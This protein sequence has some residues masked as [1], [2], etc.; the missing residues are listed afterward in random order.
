LRVVA[1]YVDGYGAAESVA[2]AATE[3]VANVND[4]PS[5]DVTLSGNA[6]QYESLTASNALADADGLGNVGYQWQSSID[7][8]TWSAING[9]TGSS[10]VLGESQVGQRVRVIANYIDGHGSAESVTSATTAPVALVNRVMGTAG[11]DVL[12]GTAIADRFEGLEG[13]DTY[14]VD[15]VDDVVIENDNEGMDVVQSAVTYSLSS[16]VEDLYLTGTDAING[17]GNALGNRL[18]GNAAANILSGLDGNDIITDAYG[19]ADTLIGGTGNDNLSGGD[20]ADTYVFARGFGQDVIA[21]YDQGSGGQDIIRFAADILA[22][23]V[24]LSRNAS[25]LFLKVLGTEDGITVTGFYSDP[26]QSIERVEFADSTV[27]NATTLVAATFFGTP[28]VDYIYGTT[29]NDTLLGLAGNDTLIADAGNDTLDGGT[30]NDALD[31]GAGNDAFIFATGYGQDTISDASGT[32]VITLGSGLTNTDVKIWRDASNLYVGITGTS[33]VLTVQG[34]YDLSTNRVESIKFADGTI[35]SST[36]L[37]AAPFYGATGADALYGTSGNDVLAGFAGD[38]SLAGDAGNDTLDG[39]TGNDALDGGAGNDSFIFATGYGQDTISDMSGTDVIT[40]GSGLTTTDVKIWRDTSN[41]YVGITGTSDVLTVQGWYDLTTNRV[42]SIKFADGTIWN[43]TTLA[44]APFFGTA[45]ADSLAGT[46][47]NDMLSGFSGNDALNGDA[48]NDTLDGGTGIDYLDGGAG[49]DTYVFARGYGQDTVTDVSG[50]DVITLG[51]GL[52]TADVKIW[53]DTS[54]LYV[55]IAGTADVLTVQG[56]YDLSTNRVES[57]KFADGTIWSATTLAAAPFFGTSGADSLSGTTGNDMLSGFG[58]NDAVYA[59]AGNDT[60]D[61]GTGNDLLDGGAGNDIYLFG[62]GYG[63]DTISETSGTADVVQM[64]A[65]VTPADIWVSRDASNLYLSIKGTAD[66]LSFQNWYFGSTYQIEQIKFADNTTWTV[67]DLNAKTSSMTEGDDFVWGTTGNDTINGLGGDDQL[68]GSDGNDTLS[69]GAGNDLLNGGT[70]IDSMVGGTGDDVYVVNI[71]GDAV[72]ELANE[73]TDTV[74]SSVTHTLGANVENLTLLDI[75]GAINGTGNTLDNV[76]IG[77]SVVNTLNGGAGA[78]TLIGGLGND[79]Y[80]V[81]NTGDSIV[82][83]AGEGTDTVQASISY[84]L[85]ANVENLTLTGTTALSGTGND[86]N[87]S[88]TGNSGIN[89]LTGGAG[90]DVLNGGAGA[91]TLIGGLGNDTYTVDNAGD[92]VAEN[93][94]EGTDVV[95]STISYTLGADVE[96]LTLTGAAITSGTGNELNNALTGNSAANTLSGGAGNDTLNGGAGADTLN[97]GLGNDSYT[98]DN[99]GDVIVESADEGTDIVNSSVTHSLAAN[100]ENLTLTGAAVINGTGNTFDNVLTGNSAT[101]VLTGG[102]GNDVLN[103]AAGADTLIGGAGNDTYTA[104]NIGDVTVENAGEGTDLVNSAV[105][106]TLGANLENLTLTGAAVINGTG[107]TLDNVLTGNSAANLLTGLGGNDWLDGGAGNDTLVGGIGDDTYVVAQAADV[108]TENANEGTDTVRSS[109]T[110]TLGA[111]LENLLLTSGNI[112]G[113]GN[114]LDNLIT[115]S[116]GNN[117]LTGNAGNDT[118]DG[119]AGTDILIGGTGSDTYLFGAGYGSDTIRENDATAGNADLVQVLSGTSADQLWLRHV[120]NNLEASIMGTTDKL[121]L[122]NW[123]LGAAYHVEQFR[124][125][126]GKLLLDSQVEN[127]VQA[128]AAFAPPGA[129]QTTLPPAYQDS[130]APVIAANWQ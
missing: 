87:N 28:G 58:G 71:A 56:W 34:W 2:G 31:G 10:L 36:T 44:A 115:G 12:Y 127:L 4:A 72:T 35:W 77:N 60:L 81:E 21:E 49:N 114:T 20:G 24:V 67:A 113:T 91:D 47:G 5:G 66:K 84:T 89:T 125:A 130:L 126:D 98:V 9:A 54:N 51:S 99:V 33:D 121:T 93:A 53:R 73:G 107:N 37:A 29:A 50:T 103:G 108:A 74:T 120:G 88:L 23:D 124:T 94:G 112:S 100:V 86:L 123:Y 128:M 122:E 65:D 63:Q 59:D 42:E 41:L 1:S 78:D 3:I 105:A 17:S 43:T 90:N 32:D 109:V 110:W 106:Y 25:D 70:G 22:A 118:L 101:N 82:E 57:V 129:G 119:N 75:G 16:N 96:N 40:M 62:R 11:V 55:G 64:A 68:M 61:G 104:D 52:T 18:D 14:I 45:G 83:Q 85:A 15:G 46:I 117:T 8:S 95:N 30:G 39:G 76:I 97:G 111:N 92:V 79:I 102:A 69:G 26:A 116:T 7:G 6:M 19:G 13:S 38:D 27:W 80:V 48:G